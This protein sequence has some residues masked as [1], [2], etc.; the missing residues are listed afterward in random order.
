MKRIIFIGLFLLTQF[1][2]SQAFSAVSPSPYYTFSLHLPVLNTYTLTMEDASGT[3]I[4]APV[5]ITSLAKTVKLYTTDRQYRS[6]PE[7]LKVKVFETGFC[8][9]FENPQHPAFVVGSMAEHN[10]L[11]SWTLSITESRACTFTADIQ[12]SCTSR[13]ISHQTN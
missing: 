3:D 2:I 13:R 1:S 8:P 9:P 4:G 10:G 5:I 7:N 6:F 11:C 12:K